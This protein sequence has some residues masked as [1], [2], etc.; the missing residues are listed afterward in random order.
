M[1]QYDAELY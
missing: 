1:E